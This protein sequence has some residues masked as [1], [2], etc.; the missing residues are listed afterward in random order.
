MRGLG[1]SAKR[2]TDGIP[3]L[4]RSG[5]RVLV[6]TENATHPGD[7]VSEW[8]A[9]Q[10][11]LGCGVGAVSWA[12]QDESLQT[13]PASP[14]QASPLRPASYS[15]AE[16]LGFQ[17]NSGNSSLTNQARGGSLLNLGL[18]LLA[19]RLPKTTTCGSSKEVHLGIR[20]LCQAL[21]QAQ[22]LQLGAH[23]F[24][25]AFP[26]PTPCQLSSCLRLSVSYPTPLSPDY[27]S[28]VNKL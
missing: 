23:P 13:E 20:P 17:A 2:A 24:R 1:N 4:S 18:F 8:P 12:V 6:I 21:W 26:S 11:P 7:G 16:A 22:G 19:G 3:S 10:G 15:P 27:V 9:G 5:L 28:R 25:G 14:P